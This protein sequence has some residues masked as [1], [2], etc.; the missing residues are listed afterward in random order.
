MPAYYLPLMRRAA[1][2]FLLGVFLNAWPFGLLPG[3]EFSFEKLRVFGVL[4][5]IAICVLVGGVLMRRVVTGERFSFGIDP[6]WC[7]L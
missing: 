3:S 6:H 1:V 2:L 5:R 4:Q 7:C